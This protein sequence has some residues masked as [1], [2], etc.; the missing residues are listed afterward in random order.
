MGRLASVFAIL[1]QLSGCAVGLEP[2]AARERTDPGS[3]SDA[4][5]DSQP[6]SG[7]AGAA[8]SDGAASAAPD[9]DTGAGSKDP[10]DAGLCPITTDYA[11]KY[12]EAQ[13]DGALAPCT[14]SSCAPDECCWKYKGCV[15]Q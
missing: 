11:L 2:L 14:E 15:A 4:S 1:V 13:K 9:P 7:W 10:P 8:G 6:G 12:F 5:T 3:G